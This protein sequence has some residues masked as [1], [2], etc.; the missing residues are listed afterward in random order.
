MPQIYDMGPTALLPLRRKACWGFFNIIYI[1]NVIPRN[2]DSIVGTRK[3]FC[4]SPQLQNSLGSMYPDKVIYSIKTQHIY[5]HYYKA[6]DMFRLTEPSSGQFLI[7]SNGTFSECAHY[8]IPYR[9]HVRTH[10]MYHYFVLTIVLQMVQWTETCCQVCSNDY[11]YIYMLC[12]DWIYY[13]IIVQNNSMAPSKLRVS[14]F[15]LCTWTVFLRVKGRRVGWRNW[16]S[17]QSSA[18]ILSAWLY[19]YLLPS[20]SLHDIVIS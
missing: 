4:S 16:D 17:H 18:G 15:P 20:I 5:N 13:S 3:I 7:Q 9:L 8:M 10:W 19:M 2:R 1:I 6:G 14:Y 12:L 11:I